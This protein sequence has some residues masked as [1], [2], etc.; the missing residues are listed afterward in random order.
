MKRTRSTAARSADSPLLRTAAF[1]CAPSSV[2]GFQWG[3]MF[4][5]CQP[6]QNVLSHKKARACGLRTRANVHKRPVWYNWRR[7]LGAPATPI[8]SPRGGTPLWGT[9]RG[10]VVQFAAFLCQWGFVRAP[11][12][13]QRAAARWR[14]PPCAFGS[15]RAH[16]SARRQP[17]CKPVRRGKVRANRGLSRRNGQSRCTA[18][19]C[20]FGSFVKGRDKRRCAPPL[21]RSA[22]RSVLPVRCGAGLPLSAPHRGERGVPVGFSAC[23]GKLGLTARGKRAIL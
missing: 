14:S 18:P 13:E 11:R 21:T 4:A 7:V 22:L 3:G 20:V 15:L 16:K 23:V 9:K 1:V 2:G 19:H 5:V 10:L 8:T 6:R 17:R 12:G